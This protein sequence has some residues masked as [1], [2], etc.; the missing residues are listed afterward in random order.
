MTEQDW[1]EGGNWEL[2]LDFIR[3]RASDRKLR[4]LAI[5]A[6]R[7]VWN[8]MTDERSRDAVRVAEQLAEGQASESERASIENKAVEARRD[9]RQWWG[10]A[11]EDEI[12]SAG[13]DYWAIGSAV[14]A[15]NQ[16]VFRSAKEAVEYAGMAVTWAEH[17]ELALGP[18]HWSGVEKLCG[19]W[20][21]LIRDIFGNPFR[22]VPLDRA[23]LTWNDGLIRQL[24][25]LIYDGRAF[26]RLPILADALEDAGCTDADML[27][28]V[29]GTE[30]HV[31]GCWVVDR[32]LGKS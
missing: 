22:L 10:A 7:H 14:G 3:N 29:R 8:L 2:M 23:W 25:E 31:R 11:E 1:M 21:E 6:C 32:I 24:A 12:A 20:P 17:D 15:V 18:D 5:A 9:A 26:D 30:P 19:A 28:H 16:A 4:L 27:D 13:V